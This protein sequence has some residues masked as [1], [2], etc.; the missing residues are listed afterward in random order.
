[1]DAKK[2]NELLHKEQP[3]RYQIKVGQKFEIKLPRIPL[4]ANTEYLQLVTESH[5]SDC[6][7]EEHGIDPGEGT[8]V[9][10]DIIGTAAKAG[11][12][13]YVIRAVNAI[14]Q[15]EIKGVDPLEIEVEVEE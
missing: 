4:T 2:I 7:S 15:E 8:L 11:R 5:G 3:R 9:S 1:M 14:S 13:R 6:V 12:K 10:Q